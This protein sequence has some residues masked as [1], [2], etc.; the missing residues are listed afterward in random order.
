MSWESAPYIGQTVYNFN[1]EQGI[2]T[3][4]LDI[5]L[6][7]VSIDDTI[8]DNWTNEFSLAYHAIIDWPNGEITCMPLN[9]LFPATIP[10]T[11]NSENEI[12]YNWDWS[13]PFFEGQRVTL[14][15]KHECFAR[16]SS[17]SKNTYG[18][19]TDITQVTP[20]LNSWEPTSVNLNIYINVKW[21]CGNTNTYQVSSLLPITP[22]IT[23]N[24]FNK[25]FK[26]GQKVLL[27]SSHADYNGFDHRYNNTA[28]YIIN[29]KPR[30]VDVIFEANLL[31]VRS[32]NKV[33][34]ESIDTEPIKQI[35]KYNF[36]HDS[37]PFY[38]IDGIPNPYLDEYIIKYGYTVASTEVLN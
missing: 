6:N 37:C 31:D 17:Q 36:N 1:N 11:T 10:L 18:I 13:I 22:I 25:N 32:I 29:I 34:L 3:A 35:T 24:S 33:F 5:E 2:I 30:V 7:P 8:I 9:N 16:Y 21:D 12:L 15:P 28:A 4:L 27:S 19:I 26:I 38:R 14:N 20:Y 23:A